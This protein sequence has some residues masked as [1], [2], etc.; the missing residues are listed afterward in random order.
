MLF[1]F[2]LYSSMLCKLFGLFW[3]DFLIGKKYQLFHPSWSIIS[4][5]HTLK[6]K[7]TI[8]TASKCIPLIKNR[9]VP[10]LLNY[11]STT[12]LFSL[13]L[14]EEVI[15]KIINALNINKAHRHHEISIR[16]INLCSKSFVKPLSMIFNNCID[17]GIFPDICKRSNMLTVYK[18]VDKHIINNYRPVSLLPIFGKNFKKLLFSSIIRLSPITRG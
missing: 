13:Y 15:L 4:W 17:T 9:T 18:K 5:N 10:N 7:V 12:R 3:K 14:N 6:L 16:M 11:V 8:L 1:L 2:V